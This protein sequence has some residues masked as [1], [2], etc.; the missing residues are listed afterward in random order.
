MDINKDHD[1]DLNNLHIYIMLQ[2]DLLE[3]ISWKSLIPKA[4]L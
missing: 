1:V 2:K 4:K 3:K